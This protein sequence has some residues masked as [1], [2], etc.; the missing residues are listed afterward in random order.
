MDSPFSGF[1]NRGVTT[2]WGTSSDKLLSEMSDD[3][4]NAFLALDER[5]RNRTLGLVG[6]TGLQN[7]N[8]ITG[9]GTGGIKSTTPGIGIGG[10][11]NIEDITKQ[12]KDLAEFRLGLD[13]RGMDKT[14][15]LRE[16]ESANNF[17]RTQKLTDQTF[18]W[19]RLINQDTEGAK[20]QRNT[21]QLNTQQRLQS[22]QINQENLA[23]RR[24]IGLASKRL[25]D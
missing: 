8:T 9:T 15:S 7:Q 5:N 14:A 4:Y 3:E 12:A 13:F 16:A 17:G 6:A 1:S 22:N 2:A 24:A 10:I 19:Q 20:T 23:A 21:D 11:G 25:G 18:N